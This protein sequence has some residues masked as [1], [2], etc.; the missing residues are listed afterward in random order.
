MENF[1]LA[2]F[3]IFIRFPIFLSFYLFVLLFFLR[4]PSCSILFVSTYKFVSQLAGLHTSQLFSVTEGNTIQMEKKKTHYPAPLQLCCS[5][6]CSHQQE[7]RQATSW[8]SGEP[9]SSSS[10]SSSFSLQTA[11][12]VC[13]HDNGRIKG[14]GAPSQND[15]SDLG[16]SE[17]INHPRWIDRG[18]GLDFL[19]VNRIKT[20]RWW[21]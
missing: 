13:F 16:A 15:T 5:L 8:K 2:S 12:K 21:I 17:K 1:P 9:S 11:Q 6:C 7:R 20:P 19:D 10:S 14:E 3:P 18:N 4:S